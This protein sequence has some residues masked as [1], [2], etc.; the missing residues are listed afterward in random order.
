M[1][2]NKILLS[3]AL[4]FGFCAPALAEAPESM[5]VAQAK[6]KS[7]KAR[8]AKK[9][10]RKVAK[11]KAVA[12]KAA[13]AVEMAGEVE[14]ERGAKGA[15]KSA[16]LTT[17]DGEKVQIVLNPKGRA[18]AKL[19]GAMKVTGKVT[20]SKGV[21]MLRVTT[22]AALP[23]PVEEPEAAEVPEPVE[24]PAAVIGDDG[25]DNAPMNDAPNDAPSDDD[26]GDNGDN[27]PMNDD[28]GDNPGE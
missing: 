22:F 26:N 28:D 19:G 12:K 20:T 6:G 17:E 15:I 14:V 11:K 2:L 21:K 5:M 13:P 16:H 8:R 4:T 18:L 25:D 24:P 10:S 1:S 3:V 27:A 9:V 23:K 7:I